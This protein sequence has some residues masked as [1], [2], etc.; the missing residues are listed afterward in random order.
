MLKFTNEGTRIRFTEI[1]SLSL[2]PA[3]NIFYSWQWYFD[4]DFD[5]TSVE[6]LTRTCI[7]W[8]RTTQSMVYAHPSVAT[9]LPLK[10]CRKM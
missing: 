2:M 6:W 4:G 10:P 9:G 8:T 1:T 5:Q 3:F 7:S